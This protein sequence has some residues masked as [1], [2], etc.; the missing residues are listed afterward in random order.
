MF[1]FQLIILF[2]VLFLIPFLA[3]FF[4]SCSYSCSS[5]STCSHL[6][7]IPFPFLIIVMFPFL[8]IFLF[9]FPFLFLVLVMIPFLFLILFLF[10]S[11]IPVAVSGYCFHSHHLY[12][13]NIC[14]SALMHAWCS[15][16]FQG[17][18]LHSGPPAEFGGW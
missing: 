5:S 7:Q 13:I 3:T 9:M 4:S 8:F 16:W 17:P 1:F 2:L 6:F 12:I 11:S 15:S 14:Q 18:A 10:P